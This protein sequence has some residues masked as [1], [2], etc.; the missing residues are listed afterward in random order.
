MP[1]YSDL[2]LE[3][4]RAGTT[5]PD[6]QLALRACRLFFL[7]ERTK[8]EIAKQ[9]GVSRFKVSRL[10]DSARASGLV[11]IQI[12][13]P[14]AD[15]EL[16]AQVAAALSLKEASVVSRGG[17]DAIV[18]VGHAAAR[19][20]ADRLAPGDVLGIAW[21]RAVYQVVSALESITVPRPVDV[22][23]LAG[24]VDGLEFPLN[25][26]GLAAKAAERFAGRLYAMHAPAFVDSPAAHRALMRERSVAETI[27]MFRRVNVAVVG[28]GSWQRVVDS[29]LYRTGSLPPTV[30]QR[31]KGRDICGDVF[32][33]FLDR[34]GRIV[35]DTDK[36]AIAP[37]RVEVE[38]MHLRVGVAAGTGKVE[39]IRAAVRSGLV[40]ALVTDRATAGALIKLSKAR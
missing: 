33:R 21:G 17:D 34:Q 19:L 28:I 20:I 32:S 16:G 39:A 18:A 25:A 31:L 2:M 26:I 6:E 10:I 11:R 37:T 35:T 22:V 38:A 4:A 15:T 3:G 36:L 14:G 9:L 8:Q 27:S 5:M 7:E 12:T 30:M 40:N 23:Q 1:K 24:G 13:E 29:S